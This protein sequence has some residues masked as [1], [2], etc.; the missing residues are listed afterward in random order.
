MSTP[1]K[2]LQKLTDFE[3]KLLKLLSLERVTPKDISDFT[4]EDRSK[5]FNYLRERDAE[6]E[7]IDIDSDSDLLPIGVANDIFT[8]KFDALMSAETR[9]RKWEGN[10]NQIGYLISCLIK[11]RGR[12][13]SCAEIA[14]C[15]GLSRQ[16]ITK[17]INEYRTHP[18]YR[19]QA[20]QFRLLSSRLL[21]HIYDFAIK[22]D[23][24]AA[25]LYFEATDSIGIRNNTFIQ[26]QN[27][28][29]QIN[30]TVLSQENIKRLKPKQL[31]QI[32]AI[33]KTVIPDPQTNT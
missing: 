26:N 19:Q 29:I 7:L 31:K 2:S 20:E 32:E 12:M 4:D 18:L 11:E 33:I 25:R 21:T 22:G 9:N 17:H 14:D 10:H 16:T 30:K 5:F 6:R 8:K 13:P 28:Y 27:N 24:R 15:T 1:E 23:M 3:Q